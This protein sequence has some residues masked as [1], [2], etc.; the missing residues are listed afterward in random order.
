[1]NKVSK[2]GDRK[3][4]MVTQIGEAPNFMWLHSSEVG[5]RL[6]KKSISQSTNQ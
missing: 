6:K 3:C 4:K 1:M 5:I 2:A